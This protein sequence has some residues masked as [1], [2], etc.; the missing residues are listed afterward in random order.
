MLEMMPHYISDTYLDFCKDDINTYIVQYK[1]NDDISIFYYYGESLLNC[2][3]ECLCW[4][5]E[6]NYI[7]GKK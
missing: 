4:L 6:N 2:A 5:A 3:Y 1:T 7:G